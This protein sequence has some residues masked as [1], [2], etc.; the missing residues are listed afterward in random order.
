MR[1]I[2][3]KP[4]S[5]GEHVKVDGVEYETKANCGCFGCAF[6]D[7]PSC[8]AIHGCD[9]VIFKKV[10]KEPELMTYR[11]LSEWLARGNGQMRMHDSV[12]AYSY[13]CYQ[14]DSEESQ[15]KALIRPWGSD[16]WIIPT[17]DIYE[18]DCKHE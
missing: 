11:Q 6:H 10:K 5:A 2:I 13:F 15:V 1:E 3:T 16:E 18:R 8:S 9:E 17:V 14:T 7:H 4:F 12:I